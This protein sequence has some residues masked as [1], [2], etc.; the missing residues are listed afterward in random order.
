[1]RAR[2]ALFTLACATIAAGPALAA[3]PAA[4]FQ[5]LCIG[6]EAR[7]APGDVTVVDRN[8]MPRAVRRAL[9]PST[10]EKIYRVNG[11]TAAFLIVQGDMADSKAERSC[12]IIAADIPPSRLISTMLNRPLTGGERGSFDRG[13]PFHQTTPEGAVLSAEVLPPEY[14]IATVKQ[15]LHVRHTSPPPIAIRN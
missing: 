15:G 7:F 6:G 9:R 12:S 13:N 1:M 10:T 11:G 3:E 5:K 2:L 14:V 8:A 4:L